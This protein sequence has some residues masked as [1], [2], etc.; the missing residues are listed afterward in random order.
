[1]YR[2]GVIGLGYR[3]SQQGGV[4]QNFFKLT[5]EFIVTA[6]TDIDPESVKKY[7]EFEPK[8]Y[9]K[10]V[11]IYEDP[12]EMMDK[13]ELDGILIGTRCNLHTEMAIKVFKR[14]IP[15]FLEKPVAI[16]MDEVNA[17]QEAA[18]KYKPLVTVS[19]PLRYSEVCVFVK[20]LIDSGKIGKVLQVDAF[21]DV[22]Y[23]RVYYKDHYRDE[24]ETGGLWLQKATHDL[25]YLNYLLGE[26]AES[27][28]AL[29]V[30]EIFKGDMPAGSKCEGC[31]KYKTCTESPYNLNL[32]NHDKSLGGPMC[33]FAEDTGNDDC[34]IALIKYKS[35]AIVSYEQNFFVRHKAERRGARLY[36]YKGTIEF[37][38][39][40]SEV[41]VYMHNSN[42]VET[43]T[44]GECNLSH[45]GGDV[46]LAQNFLSQMNGT[47]DYS[48]IYE[49]IESA[50]M[51]LKAKESEETG[52]VVYL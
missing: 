51:C 33:C 28:Y 32:V 39:C 4:L 21:N 37:D 19:F 7:M 30:R 43:Y 14:G 38:W 24:S 25:D 22:P 41:K 35:G 11:P 44:F 36:G 8:F 46:Q 31:E 29:G 20:N 2:L 52:Q 17:L 47:S 50:R 42:R 45:F 49:G 34:N 48:Y 3:I 40:K 23:G 15:L 9:A 1:M 12:E 10:D 6:I 5:D 27:I 26:K 18:D 16:T 13:E